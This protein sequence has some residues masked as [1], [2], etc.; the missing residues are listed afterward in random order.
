MSLLGLA[1]YRAG[2][3]PAPQVQVQQVRPRFYNP[4]DTAAAQP[5]G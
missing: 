5:A 4:A 3:A 2:G 1:A